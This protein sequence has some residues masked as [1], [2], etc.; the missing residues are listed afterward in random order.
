MPQVELIDVPFYPQQ[1]YHCGPASLAAIVNYRGVSS[2]PQD[3]ARMVYV[4]G[5]KGSLQVEIAAATRRL[6]LLA[7]ET[8]GQLV[9]LLRELD[10]GNPV[11]VLQNLAIDAFPVW[12][13]EV[14]IGYDLEKRQLIL[15]SGLNRR[16]SRS[17]S[18]FEKTWQRAGHWALVVVGPDSIPA[19]A[20]VEAYLAAVIDME[21]V[22]RLDSARQG[23]FTALERWPKNVLALAGLGN[24]SYALG[25]YPSAESAY[26]SALEIEPD[27]PGLWNNLAYALAQLGRQ[28]ESLRAIEQAL[29]ID[30]ANVEYRDSRDEIVN[31]PG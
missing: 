9:S 1:E 19:S 30:P 10:A 22:G 21:Q 16:I 24:S 12:H 18:L 27:N 23:Y 25:F 5:L 6:G 13:Y 11:F 2:N 7:V 8:D 31:W 28:E 29:K 15:R 26:R 3:I 17:F 20:S 4:P 14:L